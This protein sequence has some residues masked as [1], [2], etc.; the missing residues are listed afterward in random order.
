MKVLKD[1]IKNGISSLVLC[2]YFIITGCYSDRISTPVSF[3]TLSDSQLELEVGES[4]I[5]ECI[6]SP[7]NADNQ[8]IIWIS[9]DRSIATVHEGVV[10]GIKVGEAMITA[11]SDDGGKTAECVITV[12]D[13]SSADDDENG[14]KDDEENQEIN[15]LS[16]IDLSSS[17][18]ANCYLISKGGTYKF[19]TVKGNSEESVGT[20]SSCS[21][22]W[23]SFGTDI[24]PSTNELIAGVYY[25][26]E[27][28]AFNTAD[29]FKEGN[30]VIAAEDSEGNILWSW[31]IWIVEEEIKT[32]TYTNNAGI[33]MDRNLGATSATPGDICSLGLLYQW[34]RKD[35]FMGA[36]A[37]EPDPTEISE[38]AA[39]TIVW[40]EPV[41]SDQ[42]CGTIEY[43]TK[44]PTTF[45]LY[46]E[47][48]D[49]DWLYLDDDT[50]PVRWHS[51]KTIYDPCPAGWKVADLC[52]WEKA[53]LSLDWE[54]KHDLFVDDSYGILLGSDFCT[55]SAWY[56]AAGYTYW[57]DDMN[58]LVIE[59]CGYYGAYWSATKDYENASGL[60]FWNNRMMDGSW[61]NYSSCSIRCQKI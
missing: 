34:G 61:D 37:A 5:I 35:P 56:P 49:W 2:A 29:T 6:V 1:R 54:T 14:N 4:A 22:L 23:E 38:P 46:G 33:L 31:H 18:T 3:I 10:Q 26:D 21:L 24:K 20:V 57:Y 60:F 40:P 12:T 45:I 50:E 43:A 52:V 51:D 11:K 59:E 27:Y 36:G 30:A 44:H 17:G 8:K 28:I 58:A 13:K 15:M 41:V 16:A 53:G 47:T 55:P 32:S 48:Y 39:S 19:R 9:S 25:K 7:Y 42:T